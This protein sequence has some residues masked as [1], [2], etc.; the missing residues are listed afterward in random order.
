MDVM[1][2]FYEHQDVFKPLLET[3]AREDNTT[4]ER[5][6]TSS[7]SDDSDSDDD[8]E[9][10]EVEKVVEEEE[11]EDDDDDSYISYKEEKDMSIKENKKEIS[12]FLFSFKSV[13][14]SRN[15]SIESESLPSTSG[16][17]IPANYPVYDDLGERPLA[18]LKHPMGAEDLP[19]EDEILSWSGMIAEDNDD[20]DLD[21][22]MKVNSTGI[23]INVNKLCYI[24]LLLYLY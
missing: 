4:H 1:V 10:D 20:E 18:S 24:L 9:D 12:P 19:N 22:P 5:E 15:E 8:D 2:W 21:N 7:D 6:N 14:S 3:I 17:S 11:E 16:I 23:Y 13:L